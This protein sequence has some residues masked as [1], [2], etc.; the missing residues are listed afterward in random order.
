VSDTSGV[1]AVVRIPADVSELA[2][3]RQ[4]IREHAWRAGA[5]RQATDDLVQA[6]DESVT[7][8]IVHGYQGADG[9]VEVELEVEQ[10]GADQRLVVH[11]RDQAPAFDPTSVPDPDLSLPLE[12]RPFHGMGVFLTRE[13]TDEV[14]YRRTARGN[15]LTLV[16]QLKSN[17]GG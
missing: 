4:F 17:E 16:K 2:S 3:V 6:V 12:R 9:A 10:D 7:N 15:E 13:L 8:A 1:G 14:T 5:D 11:L